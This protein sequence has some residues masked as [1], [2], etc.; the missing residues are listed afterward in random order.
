MSA[1]ATS[2]VPQWREF[3]FKDMSDRKLGLDRA[4]FYIAVCCDEYRGDLE[5]NP[6]HQSVTSGEKKLREAWESRWFRQA[7]RSRS[8]GRIIINID[9]IIGMDTANI[10]NHEPDA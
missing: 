3:V 7:E 1:T 5:W 10:R 8:R 6:P 9:Y 2:A 4:D